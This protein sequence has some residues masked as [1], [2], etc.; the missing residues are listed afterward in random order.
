MFALQPKQTMRNNIQK[1]MI[2][3]TLKGI[4]K[5]SRLQLTGTGQ[6]KNR[7]LRI[8]KENLE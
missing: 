2:K 7:Y 3:N 8:L 4:T 6:D 5:Y 1:E